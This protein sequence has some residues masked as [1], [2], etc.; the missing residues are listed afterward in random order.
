M[1]CAIKKT[2][3]GFLI[4][5]P[6]DARLAEGE[7]ELFE[8]ESGTCVIVAQKARIGESG[9][10]Q[11]GAAEENA[12]L[13]KLSAI[14]FEERTPQ[15]VD[16]SLSQKEIAIL[17]GLIR[18]KLVNVFYG[19]KYA[20]TGVYNIA[21]NA[22][23]SA[24]RP[25]WETREAQIHMQGE[26]AGT[27]TAGRRAFGAAAAG[28]AQKAQEHGG[29]PLVAELEKNG[30]LVVENE[31]E[32]RLIASVLQPKIASGDV[33]GVR[34]FDRKYYVGTKDFYVQHEAIG[35]RILSKPKSAE[36]FASEA[37]I[38]RDAASALLHLMCEKGDAIEK[39][40]GLFEKA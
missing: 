32:A 13:K 15:K 35:S 29:I 11:A 2:Q 26:R 9:A 17:A 40:K 20:K 14:K 28:G 8:T 34:G 4:E 12:L 10:M 5:V 23:A 27:Q 16:G 19:K 7:A 18:K 38:S 37:K 22:F 33:L 21:A 30:F 3:G 39:K 6:S 36:E 1:K 24:M 25:G 31:Q